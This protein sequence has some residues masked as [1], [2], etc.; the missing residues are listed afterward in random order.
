MLA[1]FWHAQLGA[2]V[3]IEDYVHHELA[4]LAALM[5][6]KFRRHRPG[7]RLRAG[8]P[9]GGPRELK[10]MP[11]AYP[12]TE[13]YYDCLVVGRRRR[14]P[15][16]GGGH[17][18]GR[19]E[20][21]LHHQGLPHPL[22]HRGGPGRHQR[23]ARQHERGR[24][25]LPHVRHRQG[26]GLAGRPGRHRVHDQERAGRGLR[27]RALRR[28]VLAHPSRARSTSAPSAASRPSTARARPT[29]PVPPPTAPATSCCTR[30]SSRR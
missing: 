1:L 20:G 16:R 19:A 2:Q 14:R 15:A 21:R 11:R 8:G 10:R 4:K 18:R 22:A 27:A 26:V 9:Q 13:H 30:C 24:L 7:P 23:R 28:A 5:L 6:V 3:I 25:A 12:I 17:G 29:A